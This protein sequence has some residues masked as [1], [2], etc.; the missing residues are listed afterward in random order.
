[1]LKT[2]MLRLR[3]RAVRGDIRYAEA[4]VRHAEQ[5]QRQIAAWR[6]DEAALVCE[7]AQ[8]RPPDWRAVAFASCIG[9]ALALVVAY[10]PS[11]M[12]RAS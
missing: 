10:G 9:A 5:Q 8:I 1:M 7:L 3:L 12:T 4:L 6:R 2:L 11:L